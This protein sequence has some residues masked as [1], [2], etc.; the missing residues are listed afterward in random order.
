MPTERRLR[1][2]I[3]L[4]CRNPVDLIDK[5]LS[6]IQGPL[7]NYSH[8]LTD[9]DNGDWACDVVGDESLGAAVS[10]RSVPKCE[11]DVESMMRRVGCNEDTIQN[12]LRQRDQRGS[13]DDAEGQPTS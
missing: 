3:S 1:A 11:V 8:E 5:L 2:N 13:D 10:V 12:F 4:S 7:R 9:R 6:I